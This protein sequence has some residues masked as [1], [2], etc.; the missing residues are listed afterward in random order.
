[1]RCLRRRSL[2]R[3]ITPRHTTINHKVRAVNKA[4]LIASQEENGLG[5]LNCLAEA[6]RGKVDFAAVTLGLVVAEPVLEEG[7]AGIAC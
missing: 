1:M 5:L 3:S 7:S 2:R 4:A 6:A